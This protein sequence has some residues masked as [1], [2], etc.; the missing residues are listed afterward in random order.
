VLALFKL[1]KMAFKAAKYE[2]VELLVPGVASTG[3]TQTQWS[4]PDLPKLRYTSLLA[5][6][7]FG[8]DT[9]TAS[10]NNVATPT[11]AILQKSYLVLYANERQD[12]Y[13][14]PLIS[15]VRT[16]ATTGASTPFVRALF[17]FQGQKVT[18]INLLFKLLAHQL[19]QRI[20]ALFSEFIT[21]NLWLL[22]HNYELQ[23]Q[24]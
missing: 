14:I 21:F 23:A 1:F 4:F 6:E 18:G 11:A 7:T 13:R 3:Q 22:Q 16:Q 24:Y 5:M 12:L 20:L 8:V 19:T 10:P 2:L 9:Q 15:L 17:E